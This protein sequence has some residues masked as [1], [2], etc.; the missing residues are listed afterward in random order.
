MIGKI[1]GRYIHETNHIKWETSASLEGEKK[2]A[3][4]NEQI[5][6]KHIL[7]LD[8]ISKFKKEKAKEYIEHRLYEQK[9][10]I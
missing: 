4:Y 2:A 1:V 10:I 9:W 3:W 7:Y 6:S 8:V 5:T